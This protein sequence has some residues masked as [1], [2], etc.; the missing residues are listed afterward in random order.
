MLGLRESMSESQ[1]GRAGGLCVS[2]KTVAAASRKAWDG[3][4]RFESGEAPPQLR[5]QS[6]PHMA[7]KDLVRM[8]Y[9]NVFTAP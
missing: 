8:R 6:S 3:D 2:R 7:A 9:E 5:Q 1:W 4:E